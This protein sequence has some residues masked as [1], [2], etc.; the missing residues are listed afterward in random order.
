MALGQFVG[1]VQQCSPEHA[2]ALLAGRVDCLQ[3]WLQHASSQSAYTK[4]FQ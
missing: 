4:V 1:L 3:S 2:Q